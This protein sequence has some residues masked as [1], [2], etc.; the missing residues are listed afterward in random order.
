MR[1]IRHRRR[2]IP[3][4]A[5]LAAAA[6]AAYDPNYHGAGDDLR[7]LGL[8]A[9]DTNLD[10]IAHAVGTYAQDPRSLGK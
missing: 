6:G 10:V 7:N 3:A 5:A 8:K 1:A 2:S 9:F 4:L